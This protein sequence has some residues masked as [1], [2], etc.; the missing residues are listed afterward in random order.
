M[1]WFSR[2]VSGNNGR[3]N[4]AGLM[5]TV[6][7]TMAATRSNGGMLPGLASIVAQNPVAPL[8]SPGRAIGAGVG[9]TLVPS[10]PTNVPVL[11]L[12]SSQ[13]GQLLPYADGGM[14]P[15]AG[16]MPPGQA[17]MMPPGQAG[18]MPPGQGVPMGSGMPAGPTRQLSIQEMQAEAQRLMQS[19]PQVF[20]QV[21]AVLQQALSSGELTMQELNTA[22]QMAVAAAQNPELYPRLRQLAI[23]QG[24][25]TDADLPVEYDQGIVFALIIAGTAIQKQGGQGATATPAQPVAQMRNG[26]QVMAHMGKVKGGYMPPEAAP[27]G[28]R[29]GR[30]DDLVIAVSG[31]EYVIPAHVVEKK[32]TEFFDKLIGKGVSAA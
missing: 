5:P 26:G 13:A 3:N 24:L 7:P 31:G 25:A 20:Q 2:M 18:M 22:I 27:S 14:V 4:G 11:D 10:A 30:E 28:G 32:G 29:T 17:G 12:R 1:S 19:N 9:P 23:Q 6:A 8:A 16:M 15:Q 21:T